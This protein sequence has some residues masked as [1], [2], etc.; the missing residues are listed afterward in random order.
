[1]AINTETKQNAH[2]ANTVH[3]GRQ[4]VGQMLYLFETRLVGSMPQGLPVAE[5]IT[6]CTMP[7]IIFICRCR[8][9]AV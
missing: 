2:Q 9:P 3:L 6:V 5:R 7:W 8:L 1:M 4:R